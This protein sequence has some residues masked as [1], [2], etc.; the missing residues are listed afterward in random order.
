MGSEVIILE[1][2]KLFL[3]AYFGYMRLQGKTE[4][5]I[6][7]VYDLAKADFDNNDPTKLEDT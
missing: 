4:E 3:S 1:G 7:A 5:E 6:Q 2:A